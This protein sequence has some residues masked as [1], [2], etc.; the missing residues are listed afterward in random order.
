MLSTVPHSGKFGRFFVT[1]LQLFPPSR[2]TCTCPSFVPAQIKPAS[3][4]DSASAKITPA[5]STPMLSGVSPPEICW[6][7]LSL[8]VRSGLMICQLLPPS[9]VTCTN[10]LP[11]YTLLWSCGEI[12]TGNS[13][14]KRYFTS[15]AVAPETLTGQTS[16][17]RDWRLRSSK[18]ATA[19]LTLPA[20]V[21]VDQIMLLSTGSGVAKPLSLPATGCQ[22]PRGIGPPWSPPPKKPP[23]CRLLLGPRKEGP[24]C[25]LP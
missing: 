18:R 13:Q 11:T 12:V 23:N 6:R 4:G 3:F 21:P 14:L 19:P 1:L 17:S 10:W 16:T 2:V 7:L 8:R 20:P 24:S 25:R 9:V 5:Y 22:T 15:A